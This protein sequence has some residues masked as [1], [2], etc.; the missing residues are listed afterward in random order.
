MND[1]MFGFK[2][3]VH[4]L[5]KMTPCHSLFAFTDRNTPETKTETIYDKMRKAGIS[6]EAIEHKMKMD[7]I[8]QPRVNLS[9]GDL[10]NVKL[11]TRNSPISPPPENKPSLSQSQSFIPSIETL[12]SAKNA[13]RKTHPL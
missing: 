9:I 3:K 2:Y 7:S 12:L 1:I 10:L 8:P 5:Q 6:T 4:Q 13:L 11:K